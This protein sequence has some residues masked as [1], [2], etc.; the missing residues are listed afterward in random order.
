MWAG[1]LNRHFQNATGLSP[2]EF[3]IQRRIVKACRLIRSSNLTIGEIAEITGF[4]DGNYF[5][6][7][8]RKVMGMSPLQYRKNISIFVWISWIELIYVW[9]LINHIFL[10]TWDIQA[11]GIVTISVN[12]TSSR[13]PFSYKK[14]LSLCLDLNFFTLWTLQFTA[15]IL[16]QVMYHGRRVWD[17][18]VTAGVSFWTGSLISG[19]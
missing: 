14:S 5:S 19:G 10:S 1:N 9:V 11:C 8:F 18:I 17:L 6:R 16:G 3:H 15:W 12:Y 2:V 7:Q 13:K 4:D